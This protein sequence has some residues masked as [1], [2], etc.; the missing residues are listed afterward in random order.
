[1]YIDRIL[2]PVVSLGI[3]K[4]LVIWTVGCT[5]HC[6]GCANPELWDTVGRKNRPVETILQMIQNIHAQQPI[7]GITI[8]GGDPLEQPE[9][10]LQLLEGLQE[11]TEDIL[12]YTGYTMQELKKLWSPSMLEDLQKNIAVLIDG[13]YIQEL[14]EE[15]AVLRGSLNQNIIYLKKQYQTE[16]ETY[17]K[18]GRIIQNVYMGNQL[19]SVGIHHRKGV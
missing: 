3:H 7:E 2:F 13:R 15:T 6:K 16:Y 14:N 4:R 8:T 17:L 12:V 5:K 18:Q 11:I 1:M 10:L 19:I 9:E